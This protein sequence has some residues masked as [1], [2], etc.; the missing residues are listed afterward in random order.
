MTN[1]DADWIFIQTQAGFKSLQKD[2]TTACKID[3]NV[4]LLAPVEDK[5]P[6]LNC[7]AYF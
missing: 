7:I 5:D 6:I 3:R 1:I 4:W 2:F